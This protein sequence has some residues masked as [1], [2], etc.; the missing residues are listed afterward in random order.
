MAWTFRKRKKIL[1][2]VHMNY[3]SSGVSFN[4]GVPGASITV[5]SKGVYANMGVPGTGIR[6]RKR[7]DSPT[8][9]SDE[10]RVGNSTSTTKKNIYESNGC[11]TLFYFI[12]NVLS[13]TFVFLLFVATITTYSKES[14]FFLIPG[15]FTLLFVVNTIRLHK[16]H[17]CS[18]VT[19]TFTI[20]IGIDLYII[21]SLI[22]IGIIFVF[23]NDGDDKFT[24]SFC[25]LFFCIAVML[26]FDLYYCFKYRVRN[27]DYIRVLKRVKSEV[28]SQKIQ[29]NDS[30]FSN[31]L[32]FI[33]KV[34]YTRVDFL[35]FSQNKVRNELEKFYPPE[36]ISICDYVVNTK[37]CE[38][39]NIQ[40][41][42]RFSYNKILGIIKVLE[43]SYIIKFDRNRYKVLANDETTAIRLLFRYAKE[44]SLG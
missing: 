40:K 8:A 6:N 4:I 39:I 35:Y 7:I 36:L 19:S 15:I 2:G 28:V 24:Y 9:I 43:K 38:L 42:F 31:E 23:L 5:G 11:M 29:A 34:D 21:I 37:D 3:G 13:Y 30:E 33:E 1:P 25:T 18:N 22:T 44:H 14:Y 12:T 41:E 17:R 20:A 27:K 10:S 26:S 32:Q 16:E